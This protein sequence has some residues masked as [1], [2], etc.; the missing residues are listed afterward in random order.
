MV[1]E[2]VY[3]DISIFE[4][5]RIIAS[6]TDQGSDISY[7]S[8]LDGY[9]NPLTSEKYVFITETDIFEYEPKYYS[10]KKEYEDGV[11]EVLL[12]ESGKEILVLEKE[13]SFVSANSFHNNAIICS[14]PHKSR[15]DE[16]LRMGII[17]FCGKLLLPMVYFSLNWLDKENDLLVGTI[18]KGGKLVQGMMKSDGCIVIPFEYDK[19]QTLE[20]GI[21]ALTKGKDISIVEAKAD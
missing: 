13:Q 5:N 10:A 12:D 17:D 18:E 7:Y 3:D 1:L 21:I 8:L 2:P 4:N 20:S 16:K 6:R 15:L 19:I 9:G 11:H 14:E